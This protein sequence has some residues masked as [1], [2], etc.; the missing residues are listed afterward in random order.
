[1]SGDFILGSPFEVSIFIVLVIVIKM[2]NKF[3]LTPWL[4]QKILC[5]ETVNKRCEILAVQLFS[6][7]GIICLSAKL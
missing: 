5:Y 2:N 6:P 1:V 3:L 4:W 7:D